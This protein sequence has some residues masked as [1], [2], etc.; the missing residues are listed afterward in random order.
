ME[1]LAKGH[2]NCYGSERISES[3]RVYLKK[4]LSIVDLAIPKRELPD[5]VE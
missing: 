4:S 5:I 1:E 3:F 2:M